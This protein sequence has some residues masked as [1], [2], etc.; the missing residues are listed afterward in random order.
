MN[1]RFKIELANKNDTP[2]LCFATMCKDEEKVILDTLK[3]VYKYIDYW[4]VLDTGSTDKTCEMI[5][6]FFKEHNIPGELWVDEWRGFEDSKTLMF[7]HCYN[8]SDFV[9]HLDADDWLVGDFNVDELY[10]NRSDKYSFNLKR[11]SSIFQATILYNNRL[12]W[13]YVGVA[14]NIIVCLDKRNHSHSN[15][16]VRN[17]TWIDNEERGNRKNDP[18]KYYKD[19]L[20]LKDQFFR[21]LYDDPFGI[22][23]R[24]V[25]YCAQSYMDSGN[26]KEAIQWYRLYTK[27]KDTWNEEQFESHKRIAQCMIQ[28]KFED[29]LIIKQMENAIKIFSDRAEP[30]YILGKYFNDK[31][32]TVMGY[33]YLTLAKAQNLED[34]LKKYILFV[35]RFNYGK[36]VNDELAVACFWTKR[37]I[38]GLELVNEIIDD[39]DFAGHRPRLEKN[40]QFLID[41]LSKT[42]KISN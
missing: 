35:N 25:F 16:F 24:S 14:H 13:K 20:A 4:I 30:Y 17:N 5:E 36:F 28:L 26:L 38:E 29:D 3:S 21:V 40:K 41:G 1:L 42:M 19:A 18:N 33:K 10:N 2:R 34:V 39:K 7:E 37:Y 11:G 32:N 8:K 27:L 9:L 31:S 6:D 15:Y 23:N 12:R 22:T